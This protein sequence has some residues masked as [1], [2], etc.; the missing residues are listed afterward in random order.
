MPEPTIDFPPFRLDPTSGRLWHGRRAL[1][2]RPKVFALL[3]YLAERPQVLVSKNELRA[4]IWSEVSVGDGV[5]KVC[6]SELR[7]ALGDTAAAPRFIEA[8]PRRG[9]RFVANVTRPAAPA[10]ES[11]NSTAPADHQDLA[12]LRRALAVLETLPDSPRRREQELQLRLAIGEPLISARGFGAPEVRESFAR[13]LALC[14]DFGDA[15]HLFPVIEGLH[16]YYAIQGDLPTAYAL[17]Q[18]MLRLARQSR[19][20]THLVE[21]HHVMG[22]MQFRRAE[23]REARR[24]LRRAIALADQRG[25]PEAHRSSGHD[26]AICCLGY[27]GAARWFSGFP[28]EALRDAAEGVRRGERLGHPFTLTLAVGNLAWIRLLR[29]DAAAGL[30]AAER[31]IALAERHGFAYYAAL[32]RMFRGWA[33][34]GRDDDEARREL[35]AGFGLCEAIGVGVGRVEYLLLLADLEAG[36]GNA[37]EGLDAL[38]E[39]AAIITRSGDRY[40]EPEVHR[41]RGNI[42]T[43]QGNQRA[44]AAQWRRALAIAHAQRSRAL[45]RRALADLRGAAKA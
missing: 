30:R 17:A 10:A 29:R 40:L 2:L 28:A 12:A 8:V 19:D 26:P 15:P 18:Q 27:L 37:S 23:L 7:R 36:C 5:L 4:A 34:T 32:G 45:E 35:H 41:L 14:G 24:H 9:Y 21:A 33:L 3:H 39:A 20:P 6:I 13:A 1:R 25:D 42:L 38:A 43:R 16:T 31:T 11:P 44:A 22:C